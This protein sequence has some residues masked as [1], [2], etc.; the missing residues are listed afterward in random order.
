MK[1]LRFRMPILLVACALSICAVTPCF[2]Q[3]TT[4]SVTPVKPPAGEGG[5]AQVGAMAKELSRELPWHDVVFLNNPVSAWLLF[6]GLALLVSLIVWALQAMVASR[7]EKI[8]QK[9]TTRLDDLAVDLIRSIKRP[10]VLL[11]AVALASK[12]LLLPVMVDRAAQVI[13][14]MA[15][16]IQLLISSRRVIDFALS[17]ILR[18]ATQA[19]GRTDETIASSMGVLRVVVFGVV[20]AI[21][22]LLALDNMGVQVTPLIAGLGI[23][24]IAVALAAQNILGDLFASV[25][26]LLDKPFVV[27]DAIMIGDKSGTVERIGIKTTR[28]RTPQGEELICANSDLLSSRVHNYKR[29]QERRVAFSLGLVYTTPPATLRRVPELVAGVVKAET[30]V[31]FDRCHLVKLNTYSIDFEVVYFVTT[32]DFVTHLDAQQA[33]LLGITEALSREGIE[34]AFPTQIG[35]QYEGGAWAGKRA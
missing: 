8:A 10:L 12:V 4:P 6:V 20:I 30:R 31:R 33:I 35:I 15:V 18:R 26:I 5:L 13:A 1:N 27:G 29:M 14:V 25:S 23:G 19:D 24:G 9:T 34:L 22:T 2:G 3:V 16:A 7:L 17:A 11:A 32:S 21:V 28:L